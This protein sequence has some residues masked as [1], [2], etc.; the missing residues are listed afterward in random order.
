MGSLAA[1]GRGD[2]DERKRRLQQVLD[3]LKVGCTFAATGIED[4]NV[5]MILD[6]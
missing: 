3:T 4:A 2:E 1:T 5:S 6:K